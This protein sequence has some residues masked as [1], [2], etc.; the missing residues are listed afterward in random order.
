M[1]SD[2]ETSRSVEH[3]GIG[4]IVFEHGKHDVEHF[5]GDMA[6]RD[7]VM[8]AAVSLAVVNGLEEWIVGKVDGDRGGLHDG[9]AKVFVAALG[10]CAFAGGLTAVVKPHV[11]S[12]GGDELFGAVLEFGMEDRKDLGEDRRGPDFSDARDGLK[13][14]LLLGEEFGET[15]IELRDL[16]DQEVEALD[17]EADLQGEALDVPGQRE[18]FFRGILETSRVV[19][20]E[21][22]STSLFE[23]AGQPADIHLCEILGGEELREDFAT[24]RPEE[25]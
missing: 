21:T 14:F 2:I 7:G 1:L 8:F 17:D 15:L 3:R 23:Q 19:P 24:G 11:D 10:H 18:G 20:S 4:T 25:V 13:E 12:G 5:V 9:G 16:F 22:A 6:E